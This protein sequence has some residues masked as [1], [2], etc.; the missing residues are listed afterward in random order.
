M[1]IKRVIELEILTPEDLRRVSLAIIFAV[2][3]IAKV[4]GRMKLLI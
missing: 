2:K 1:R 4:K 3:Q